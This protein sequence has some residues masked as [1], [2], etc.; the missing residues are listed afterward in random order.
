MR[1]RDLFADV[2]VEMSARRSRT[3]LMIVAV[4]LS[5][6]A[7]LCSLGISVTAARQ[8]DAGLAA[9]TVN[10]FTVSAASTAAAQDDTTTD[11]PLGESLFPED[12]E[13][14]VDG[15]D[16]VVASGRFLDTTGAIDTTL[17]RPFDTRPRDIDS[18]TI[19]GVTSGYL[20]ATRTTT[21]LPEP[22]YLL[23]GHDH[24]ALLGTDLAA[25]LDI[26]VTRDPAG[27]TVLIDGTPF[28]V[29]GFLTGGTVDPGR[30]LLVPYAVALGWVHADGRATMFVRTRFGAGAPVSRAAALALRPDHPQALRA[31]TVVDAS[32][33]RRGVASQLG[34]L[35]AG[36]GGLLLVLS[37]LLIA[38]SMVVAVMARTAEIGLRR[39]VGLPAR[40]VA[41][42]FLAEGGLAGLLGGLSG[43]ALA[44]VVLVVVSA[45]NHW[46]VVL[47]GLLLF[48]GPLL[49]ALTGLVSSAYPARRAA[50]VD[51]AVAVRAD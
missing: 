22:S 44:A 17:A 9:D 15:V 34:R 28:D 35:A 14:R 6:G 46:T 8:V 13:Q 49:G 40:Y 33:A 19:A 31:S 42:L 5:V 1:F 50:R 7:L 18:L 38:N 30:T 12:A 41:S 45:I 21:T 11:G 16:G 4:G 26:P 2:L 48:A 23:G 51:P 25:D 32:Q 27:L 39:A 37:I 47:P 29:V 10:V 3:V 43:S 20:A 24:V 36:V